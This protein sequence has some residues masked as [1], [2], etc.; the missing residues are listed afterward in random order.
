M[1]SPRLESL[2]CIN[3]TDKE[4]FIGTKAYNITC[5]ISSSLS[6][7]G[8]AYMLLPRQV[9]NN[10]RVR[11]NLG[12]ER[13]MKIINWLTVADVLA[14]VGILVRS[15][16]WLIDFPNFKK[17]PLA[18]ATEPGDRWFCAVTGAW[19]QYFYITTYF[20]TFCFAVD[21]FLLTRKK[22]SLM[23]LY[24]V[25][26]WMVSAS[27]CLD[28][29][30]PLYYPSLTRCER[31]PINLIPHYVATLLPIVMVMICNP[32][33]YILSARRVS[34]L[35]TVTSG[36]YT[37]QERHVVKQI[38]EKFALIITVFY[39]CWAPNVVNGILIL[40]CSAG[41][42]SGGMVAMDVMMGIL[43][44]LQ[45]FFNSLIYRGCVG[46]TNLRLAI[47]SERDIQ[48]PA[49]PNEQDGDEES[50][51]LGRARQLKSEK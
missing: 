27:F 31:N 35:L 6:I 14:C 29:L 4:P 16:A 18:P 45:A 34:G 41:E 46:C 37:D 19:I 43:N 33:L 47:T 1:A 21:V 15:S 36:R 2:C 3:I 26:S 44:P 8:A 12:Y 10:A 30:I 22:P 51:L 17:I 9:P 50:P 49:Q 20:W 42:F 23:W 32:I 25:V 11:R 39:V 13:Q 48:T 24:H 7:L 5:V 28:G 40:T 38:K